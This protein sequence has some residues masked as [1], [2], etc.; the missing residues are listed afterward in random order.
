MRV[1]LEVSKDTGAGEGARVLTEICDPEGRVR[2]GWAGYASREHPIRDMT[3]MP[4]ELFPGTWEINVVSAIGALDPGAYRLS[5][6]CDGYQADPATVAELKRPGSGKD[7]SATVTVT[8]VFPGVFRGE[9]A[10]TVDGWIKEHAVEL[11]KTDEWTLP[12]TLDRVTP[13]ASFRLEMDESV[14]NLHTDCA[15]NILDASGRAVR[16][17]GFD[18]TE[19]EIGVSL[20][21]GQE[22]ASYKLQVV[23][24]FAIAADMADWGFEVRERY[25]FASPVRGEVGGGRRGALRLYAG[26]PAELSLSFADSWPA[27]PEGMGYFGAVTFRDEDLADRRPGDR[28]GRPVLEVPIRVE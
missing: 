13:R 2:G 21:P 8:R 11:E 4:P 15:V 1:R 20:P 22:S 14:A 27:A 23:G 24:A 19:V 18:G 28:E 9:A 12:F 17:T 10:A 26:V 7:A 5:V 16:Q 25:H 6:G 3:V